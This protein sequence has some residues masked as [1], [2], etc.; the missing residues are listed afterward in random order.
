MIYLLLGICLVTIS[1]VLASP[2]EEPKEF[3]IPILDT[4]ELLLDSEANSVAN[5]LDTFFADQRADDELGRSV[6]RL[7]TQY[8]F[9][10]RATGDFRYQSRFNILLPKIQEKIKQA[11]FKPSKEK[12]KKAGSK[13]RGFFL[14]RPSEE[15]NT[16]WQFH[17]DAGVNVSLSPR[18][19][20]RARVRKNFYA[21]KIINRFVEE[22]GWYSDEQW[23][24]VL[25]LTSDKKN[26]E[27]I[28]F[29]F[30]N[31][32][33]WEITPHLATT[34]H[35]PSILQQVSD[36][37]ALSYNMR[38]SNQADGSTI[39]FS[40]FQLSTTYRRDI[41]RSIFYFDVTPGLD[42]PKFW[43]FRRNPFIMFQLEFLLGRG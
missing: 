25:S 9:R 31:E 11:Y 37:E 12:R 21:G 13:T 23:V 40:N 39:Y 32:I 2:A 34:S 14:P 29:R 16:K 41:Y 4:A 19:F 3:R 7:R 17:S 18:I 10:E 15:L 6:V 35:G 30:V 36:E 42:F 1:T 5:R 33:R 20:T 27:N 26:S 43:S 24:N 8:T 38:A 22:I 28:L